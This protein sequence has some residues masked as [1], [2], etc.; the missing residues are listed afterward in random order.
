MKNHVHLIVVPSTENSLGNMM[1]SLGRKYVQYVNW[2]YKRTGTL[3][4]GRFKSSLI[5]NDEYLTT[6]AIYIELN[7]VRAKITE[8]ASDYQWSSYRAKAEGVEDLII[9][10]DPVYKD[11]GKTDKERQMKYRELISGVSPNMI[12]L[13]RQTTQ[14][15]GIIGDE[16]FVEKISRMMGREIILRKRGRPKKSL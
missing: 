8:K 1:Q 7:P 2:T 6:C 12:E 3:W 15:G 10:M 4:E 13:I 9:E 5:S 16:Q 11:L 14:K